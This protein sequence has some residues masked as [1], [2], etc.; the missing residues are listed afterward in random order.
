MLH[1]FEFVPIHSDQ[2]TRG[3]RDAHEQHPRITTALSPNR[4]APVH[5]AEPSRHHYQEAQQKRA[6]PMAR[7]ELA[8]HGSSDE[9]TT[10]GGI[11]WTVR[12]VAA[13][14]EAIPFGSLA[15]RRAR[16]ANWPRARVRD[17]SKPHEHR[18]NDATK[19]Q[20]RRPEQHAYRHRH[21]IEHATTQAYQDSPCETET[22]YE[23]Q[24]P[25][26]QLP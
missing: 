10:L 23:K 8:T 11:R 1:R 20:A 6:V 4:N 19:K 15:V 16:I 3:F 9:R 2:L 17:H 14:F 25:A 24:R 5:E 26:E 13:W 18:E 21:H 7:I 12:S 22:N